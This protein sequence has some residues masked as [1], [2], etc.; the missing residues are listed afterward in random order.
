MSC[1]CCW[2]QTRWAAAVQLLLL[3]LGPTPALEFGIVQV[4]NKWV[5]RLAST[6]TCLCLYWSVAAAAHLTA[7]TSRAL[8]AVLCACCCVSCC[9][10]SSQL[11]LFCCV[12]AAACLPLCVMLL[13]PDSKKLARVLD[14]AQPQIEQLLSSKE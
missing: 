10:L 5:Y 14:D 6:R 11:L 1:C 12:S 8:P 4:C 2:R 7:A 3:C 13:Q 9:L